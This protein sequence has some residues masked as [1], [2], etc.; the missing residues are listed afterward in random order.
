MSMQDTLIVLAG[1]ALIAAFIL[2]ATG[3]TVGRGLDTLF[4]Q[5]RNGGSFGKNR[6]T[7]FVEG[8]G[9]LMLVAFGLASVY[10]GIV[11]S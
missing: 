10:I 1:G 4:G 9:T 11:L 3:R 5:P 2:L 8:A 7:K 6:E